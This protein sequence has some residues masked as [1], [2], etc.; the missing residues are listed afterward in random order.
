MRKIIGP[1][2]SFYQDAPGTPQGINFVRMNQASDF[3]IIRAGQHLGLDSD[4]KV[5]WRDAKAAGLPRGSYWFYDSRADP[6]QQAD[7]WFNAFEGDLGELPLF[8]DLEEAYNGPYTGWAYWKQFLDRIKSLVGR[9]EVGIYTAFYYWQNNAPNPTTQAAELEYFHRYPL[10]IANY[11]VSE[12]MVP[13]PWSANEWLFWQYTAS[14][15]GLYYGVES[16]EIDLNYFNG[17]AQ[18]FANRFNVPV[19]TDPIPPEDP[20]GQRY[21]VTAGSLN[22]RE[23]PGTEYA[24]IGL[25]AQNDIVEALDTN[26][27]GTWYRVQ[28][29]TDGLTGWSAS[30]YLV[31]LTAPPPPPPPPPPGDGDRY[32]VNAGSLYVREGPGTNYR[33][34]GS[35]VRN[36]VV[37]ELEANSNRTWLRVRRLTDGLTG[38]SSAAY[39]VRITTPP[40]PPPPPPGGQKY[41][42]TATRLHVREGPGTQYRSLGYINLNEIVTQISVNADQT[43]RQIQRADGLTGWS[44]ARYLAPY[45]APG[46]PEPPTAGDWYQVTAASATLREGP[47]ASSAAKGTLARDESIQAVGVSDDNSWLQLRR[48]DGLTAWGRAD[49]FRKLGANPASVR[50]KVFSSVTYYRKERTQPRRMVSHILEIDTRAEGFRF[51]VTPP[52]RDTIPQLCTQTTS[53]FLTENGLQIAI[54]GDG[55]YYLDP[56]QYD[57]AQYCPEGGDPVRLIGFAASRGRVYSQGE[58]GHPILYMN[59]RNEITYDSP[60]GQIYNAITGDIMLVNRGQKVTGLDATALHPRTAFGTNQNG[61][62]VYLVVVDGRETSEGATFSELADVLLAQ[63]AY[64]AMAFDGGGS[65]TMVIRG[66]DGR[67]RLLNTPVNENTVG[68][69]RAV[70]NHLGIALRT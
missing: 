68:R 6:R 35:F 63:G 44:S 38:W 25:L 31:K 42:V 23:G 53:Q 45:T 11:G 3:V 62:Y 14:G 47:A 48:V 15:D 17:D 4:F 10:W 7:L 60:K 49:Q 16:L 67:P 51:L 34:I 27:L 24:S 13:R 69:E 54:N 57:P 5:N 18:A 70:A 20:R 36:D 2:V 19:P 58:P 56:S 66:A 59:Q 41:R 43:W 65:S 46:P 9:K 32:R 22:V 21:R 8:A 61:R 12:P 37:E 50:Q 26:P 33:A 29:V 1:D 55:Y 39:L 40:P 64:T 52:L 28:R 30:A